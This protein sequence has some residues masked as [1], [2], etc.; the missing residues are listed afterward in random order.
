MVEKSIEAQDRSKLGLIHAREIVPGINVYCSA[1]EELVERFH[2]SGTQRVSDA[3]QSNL[4]KKPFRTWNGNKLEVVWEYACPVG[5]EV[6]P[7]EGYVRITAGHHLRK[8]AMHDAEATWKTR[9]LRR[10]ES[11]SCGFSK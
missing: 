8:I 1:E 11:V 10:N 2:S 6:I 5:N 4:C 7:R 9:Y 3:S